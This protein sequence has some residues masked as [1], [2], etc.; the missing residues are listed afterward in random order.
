M[1]L[2]QSKN[3]E[4]LFPYGDTASILLLINFQRVHSNPKI[5]VVMSFYYGL[6]E[7]KWYGLYM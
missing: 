2:Y 6:L 4:N 7:W 1:L 3:H 5:F